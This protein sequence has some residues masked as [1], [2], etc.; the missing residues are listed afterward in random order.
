[1]AEWADI[2][3]QIA[4]LQATPTLDPQVT[5]E[6]VVTPTQ[7]LGRFATATFATAGATFAFDD[8]E[9]RLST[10]SVGGPIAAAA[11]EQTGDR[12]V[13][14]RGIVEEW[15]VETDR[16]IEQ[17][18]TIAEAP[19][20]VTDELVI[21]VAAA[22][23]LIPV[24][25]APDAIGF[26]STG[27]DV[28]A[29]YSG[30]LAWDAD[31]V[32]LPASMAYV[33]DRIEITVDVA[34]AT[35]PITVDPTFSEDQVLFAGGNTAQDRNG[36]AIDVDMDAVAGPVAV[37]AVPGGDLFGND[38][39]YVNVARFTGGSWGI[40]AQLRPD[41]AANP[42]PTD[43]FG[44]SVAIFDDRI[45]VGAP[46]KDD[47]GVNSG[48]V[49]IYDFD[50]VNWQF[51]SRLSECQ[52]VPVP[53]GDATGQGGAI[54][55]R[56]GAAVAF[57]QDPDGGEAELLIGAPRS[58]AYSSD[59]GI[60][61]LYRDS[62]S[63][64]QLQSTADVINNPGFTFGDGFGSAVDADAFGNL[65]I[66]AP[67]ADRGTPGCPGP[68]LGIG[69]E[70]GRVF[71]GQ[72][73]ATAVSALGEL[74][75]CIEA[76]ARLGQDV[77]IDEDD[78][79]RR[80]MGAATGST[81]LNRFWLWRVADGAAPTADSEATIFSTSL[82]GTFEPTSSIDFDGDNLVTG[83]P[84]V[85][86]PSVGARSWN[87]GT[88]TFTSA[89]AAFSGNAGE[90]SGA[91]VAVAGP[92]VLI[93]EPGA[94]GSTLFRDDD[95]LGNVRVKALN[96]LG[97][98]TQT[99]LQS[100]Q[101]AGGDGFGSVVAIDGDI[102]AVTA[103]KEDN[104]A[105]RAGGVYVYVRSGSSQP[106]T[107]EDVLIPDAGEGNE[108]GSF[109]AALAVRGNRV[110]VGDPDN[111]RVLV[112][113]QGSGLGDWSQLGSDIVAP[114]GATTTLFFGTSVAF[115]SDADE[116]LIGSPR[117]SFSGGPLVGAIFSANRSGLAWPVSE[118][119]QGTT[120]LTDF[121]TAIASHV[122][123]STLRVVVGSPNGGAGL[124]VGLISLITR[125]GAGVPTRVD[126][127]Q[128]SGAQAG[129]EYGVAVAINDTYYAG[130]NLT[131]EV[132]VA[133]IG[134]GGVSVGQAFGN[135]SSPLVAF[136]DSQLVTGG[137]GVNE[138][139]GYD[140]PLTTSGFFPSADDEY[141]NLSTVGNPATE[142]V[143]ASGTTIVAGSPLDDT[144]F[145]T[146]SGLVVS[147]EAAAPVIGAPS[148]DIE[149]NWA[150]LGVPADDVAYVF[151]RV[152][153]VWTLRD[154]LTG[155]AG[156][157]F[158]AAVAI[159]DRAIV[160]GAPGDDTASLDAG[161]VF[162][163]YRADSITTF[164]PI[165][166]QTGGS[167]GERFGWSVDIVAE[168]GRM[169]VGAPGASFGAAGSGSVYT[170]T[171]ARG[172]TA[173]V[174]DTRFDGANPGDE[175]GSAVAL[176][177]KASAPPA[178]VI[179][180]PGLNGGDG[181][182]EVR[183]NAG[184]WGSGLS[185]DASLDGVGSGDRLGS[186]LDA[187]YTGF[188]R[189]T[190]V[191][192]MP[193]AQKAEFFDLNPGGTGDFRDTLATDS[194]GE[195]GFGSSVSIS[196]D[197]IAISSDVAITVWSTNGGADVNDNQIE[198]IEEI[199]STPAVGAAAVAIEGAL[200]AVAFDGSSN[201]GDLDPAD[202]TGPVADGGSNIG[203]IT[204]IRAPFPADSEQFG[205]P[206]V[207][208]GDTLIVGA[209]FA[210][211]RDA[212]L[213]GEVF[214]YTRSGNDWVF[215]QQLPN[216]SPLG[217]NF[218][219]EIDASPDGNVVALVANGR[220]VHWFARASASDPYV[221][222]DLI[223]FGPGVRDVDTDGSL[224][225]VVI[226]GSPDTVTVIPGGPGA[227]DFAPQAVSGIPGGSASQGE[228]A[229]ADPYVIVGS[230]FGRVSSP[231]TQSYGITTVFSL[232]TVA[233]PVL[234][235]RQELQG[236]RLNTEVSDQ[237]GAD[238]EIDPTTGVLV[239]GAAT[240]GP[241]ASADPGTATGGAY[242]YDCTG[243]LA[244]P[245]SFDTKLAAN[246]DSP[247][248]TGEDGYDV[249]VAGDAIVVGTR[250]AGNAPV[251]SN[252]TL[253]V[254]TGSAWERTTSVFDPPEVE[255]TDAYV[256]VAVS[257][258][259]VI[260]GGIEEDQFGAQAG[261]V[262]SFPRPALNEIVN[263][264]L[265]GTSSSD[266]LGPRFASSVAIDGD[267]MVV[268]ADQDDNGSAYVFDRSPGGVWSLSAE[269]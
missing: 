102:L 256:E 71:W 268:G 86:G 203:G 55:H 4:A 59:G 9:V 22:T 77:T 159:A 95:E 121:G 90:E 184:T 7:R 31:G 60:A 89:P 70:T 122:D 104:D 179:G 119:I 21:E 206:V 76:G 91:A 221:F 127:A 34:G 30:L 33:G 154:T 118:L 153:G 241:T 210:A 65:I 194:G 105:V 150:V 29:Q 137:P 93:G 191:A 62:G 83:L 182:I 170:Y 92:N 68:P 157:S 72:Y 189:L 45:A 198:V 264:A 51:G 132:A 106:W 108:D 244:A 178:L 14:D 236:D 187:A 259:H 116:V 164:A 200:A 144:G 125:V 35:Y 201:L 252:A 147:F 2:Q 143:A 171:G 46:G 85:G 173:P 73:N 228:I 6:P 88:L 246:L 5:V 193:G 218:G 249:A 169:A 237:F 61:Y 207:M 146:D 114:G 44:E 66:G 260:L 63:G 248:V 99:F 186:A 103:T 18:W 166:A 96:D 140:F 190:V 37:I 39:G 36:S 235:F 188:N 142:S 123:G 262:V 267:T 28:V 192:A 195:V 43:R 10:V 247:F 78:T 224:L 226:S 109:G 115:G 113:Q 47:D 199:S 265:R 245:C 230:S 136:S 155:A 8:T 238:L 48:M 258:T 130:S 183:Q 225:G 38:L 129:D 269:L 141:E 94:L 26:L 212:D 1:A 163:Y 17:G 168:A 243:P 250:L 107:L 167:A 111:Q 11:P 20:G 128:A 131:G 232:S 254:N 242:V 234:S 101:N 87:S 223:D 208:R 49:Y 138:L 56:F 240:D 16:G 220:E 172:L 176:A 69:N 158:G 261:A 233:L 205:R 25:L 40:V 53:C 74:D 84:S 216:T 110:A 126:A 52:S 54:T 50:G 151:E 211:N 227:W 165:A 100:I 175:Y 251:S 3:S 81:T 229:V 23:E 133:E 134:S 80:I 27:G 209:Q 239:I 257:G 19:A 204:K 41:P 197:S 161:A 162:T 253:Y 231:D 149:K 67:D 124:D 145:A 79:G 196:G 32:D 152:S 15:F 214:V 24:S 148:V 181:G 98:T 82:S 177:T 174:F 222:V 266:P 75:N 97:G 202:I 185:F 112:F 213:Q 120:N 263:P 217:T 57:A 156:T 117:A 13:Y 219:E 160:V 12:V 139:R 64:L 135:G 58:A 255:S 180:I 42:K 215:S